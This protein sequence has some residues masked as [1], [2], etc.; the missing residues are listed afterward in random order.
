MN[1]LANLVPLTP[2][3]DI[4]VEDRI[5]CKGATWC[6]S[7]RRDAH[8]D[9]VDP[10]T[11]E[12]LTLTDED[13]AGLIA[14][15]EA[16]IVRGN[17]SAKEQAYAA[18][19]ADLG[20]IS[21]V[22]V[23]DARRAMAYTDELK[24]RQLT[25]RPATPL[26]QEAISHV[27]A[28]IFDPSPPAVYLV[29]R[30]LKKGDSRAAGGGRLRS[31]T[32]LADYVPQHGF[33]GNRTSRVSFEVAQ[34]IHRVLDE[35]YLTPERR[36]AEAA[37]A[38]SRHRVRLANET[39]APADWLRVPGRKAV[40]AAI[41]SLPREE[42]I[43]RR[44]G[45]DR[46]YDAVGPV[47]YRSRPEQPLDEIEL[48]H[49]TC[50]LFVVDSLT[51]APLGRPT[52]VLGTDRC[53]AMPWGMHIGFDPPSVH[54]VM[55]CMRNGML[56]KNY[57]RIYADAGIWDI[58][59]SWPTFG[60]P[61][62]L[63]V[64]RGAENIN[65]D[66][67]ALGVDLPIKEIEAKAGRKGRLKGGIERMLG[68]L[69]RNL[70]QEQRGTTFSNVVARDDYDSKRNAIITYE[71]LLEK[72][73]QWLV[74]IYMRRYHHGVKDVPLR[75]WNSKIAS[76]KPRQVENIDK[77][78]PLFGRIEQRVLRRD[79]IRW[80]HLFYTSPTLMA[81]LSNPEFLKESR[82]A[83]GDVVVR[84]RYDPS[85][86]DHIN[87]YLPHSRGQESMHLRVPI[88][89]R[90]QDYARGLSVWAHTSIVKMSRDA[91]MTA[92][93]LAA[94][95]AAKAKLLADL[96]RDAPGSAKVRRMTRIARIRQIGGI[97]PYGD[98]V[99]T[100]PVGSFE[101]HRQRLTIDAQRECEQ[102]VAEKHRTNKSSRRPFD[103]AAQG[104][105]G[106]KSDPYAR[107]SRTSNRT[108][109]NSRTITPRVV[110]D[111]LDDG[112]DFYSDE[113]KA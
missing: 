15:G 108:S 12:L 110:S 3:F 35:L 78:L 11:A 113:V 100:T 2:R 14:A 64:D 45:A 5:Q 85:N 9:F 103:L 106:S 50:D 29:K 6:L 18:A 73:H 70:L 31:E 107:A 10:R 81:L 54:T 57:V 83:R 77:L 16:R 1:D 76:H 105:A 55:Q 30:W 51:G 109:S 36:S 89:A 47:Q 96:D 104:E 79:G 49:T 97:A 67:R 37:L 90:A 46:A 56:P 93:D 82:S 22:D 63:S 74:D 58:E 65:H 71:E 60:R 48:D 28:R 7:R 95:D 69:N 52:I 112:F 41:A 24:A 86:I 92:V 101:D 80:R 43:R 44:Y 26:V 23:E 4:T 32:T 8:L 13:L 42:V 40:E 66:M 99:R 62:K 75:L 72:T 25:Y 61:V 19:T 111:G 91:A 94:L 59:G 87:V 17:A 98:S 84:F 53:T 27:A 21:K 88:E 102:R 38:V 34:I 20:V 39:R 33:K 68:T